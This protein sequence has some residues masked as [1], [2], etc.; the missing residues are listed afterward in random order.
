MLF[1]VGPK[2][3]AL[4]LAAGLTPTLFIATCLS[5]GTMSISISKS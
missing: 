4:I 1:L 5:V 3:A 2:G